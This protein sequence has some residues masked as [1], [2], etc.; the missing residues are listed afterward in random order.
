MLN[1]KKLCLFNLNNTLYVSYVF[2]LFLMH[3]F[4]SWYA[5]N[6]F[7]PGTYRDTQARW[8]ME[9][10]LNSNQLKVYIEEIK[11]AR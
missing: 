4:F 8:S 3:I 9:I 5:Y 6:F 10:V 1:V 11:H 2:Y 7:C